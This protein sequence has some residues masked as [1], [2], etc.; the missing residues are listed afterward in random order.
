[1][2]P[3]SVSWRLVDGQIILFSSVIKT[4]PVG[5]YGVQK[6]NM[7]VKPYVTGTI[8]IPMNIEPGKWH[9]EG[10][11]SYVLNPINTQVLQRKTVDFE[12][13]P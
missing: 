13:I 3:A 7:T 12:I 6:E 2:I 11:V 4:I 8:E 1:M 10:E 5:C 9:L